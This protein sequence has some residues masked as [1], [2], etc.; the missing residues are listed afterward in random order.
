[1]LKLE[2]IKFIA[3]KYAL[4][5]LEREIDCEW[6]TG[7]YFILRYGENFNG[8]VVF[9]IK[10]EDRLYFGVCRDWELFSYLEKNGFIEGI[11]GPCGKPLHISSYKKPVGV[12]VD[13]G[14]FPLLSLYSER[15]YTLY[16][17]GEEIKTDTFEIKTLYD[18]GHLKDI[19]DEEG[20]DVILTA[21]SN[22]LSEEIAN[23]NLGID[24]MACVD[25]P[26]LDGTGLCLICRV[27]VRGEMKLNCVDG[28]WFPAE[29][30]D[31]ESLRQR[32]VSLKDA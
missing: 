13:E 7:Q 1:M 22:E 23:M 29:E 26:V 20:A 3:E 30:V 6:K 32:E 10:I 2:G 25:T 5:S 12:S 15:R 14:I 4:I 9:P 17:K 28:M 31:W 18:L 11:E 24:H 19:I 27:Y 21:G 8:Q 16:H